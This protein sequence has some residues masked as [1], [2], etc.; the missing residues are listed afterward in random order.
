MKRP[1]MQIG[2]GLAVGAGL[3]AAIALLIGTGGLWLAVGILVGIT[4][5][6]SIARKKSEHEINED[7]NLTVRS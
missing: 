6:A 5:G 4:I 7:K 3:G 1:S 2:L